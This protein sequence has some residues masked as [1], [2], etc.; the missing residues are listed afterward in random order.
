MKCCSEAYIEMSQ[1]GFKKLRM[2]RNHHR[3]NQV[4]E[5]MLHSWRANCDLQVMIYESDPDCPD[6]NEIARVTDY[7]V[8]YACKGGSTAQEEKEQIK[9]FIKK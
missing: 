9:S 8:G 4:S 1:N 6:L 3:V 7:V 2:P 5:D